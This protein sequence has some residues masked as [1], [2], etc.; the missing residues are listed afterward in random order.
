MHDMDRRDSG[1]VL[2]WGLS[3]ILAVVAVCVAH[4]GAKLGVSTCSLCAM[5]KIKRSPSIG[6][7]SD[8]KLCP[9]NN[10]VIHELQID[11]AKSIR[12]LSISWMLVATLGHVHDTA[13]TRVKCCCSCCEDS[14]HSNGHLHNI[15]MCIMPNDPSS[16]IV[17]YIAMAWLGQ[18]ALEETVC[19]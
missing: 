7:I 14:S 18:L 8:G 12:S 13:A 9:N 17:H 3:L 6:W 10:L 16:L 15:I 5:L 4:P 19:H 11:Y 2:L 1:R